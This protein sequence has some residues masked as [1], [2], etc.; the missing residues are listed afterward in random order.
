MPSHIDIAVVVE[1]TILPSGLEVSVAARKQPLASPDC[2]LRE[3][4]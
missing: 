1:E 4:G 3:Q 2:Q